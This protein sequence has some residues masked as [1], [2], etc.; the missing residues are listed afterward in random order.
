MITL[1]LAT[2]VTVA[3]A[4]MM[5]IAFHNHRHFPRL[6]AAQTRVDG[7]LASA[8]VPARNEVGSIGEIVVSLLC[9]D[10][11]CLHELLVL[12]DHSTDETARIAREAAADDP[13]F[14]LLSGAPL[15]PGW[16]GKNWAC[17]QLAQHARGD[18]LVFTD[19]DVIWQ[20]GALGAVS[21]AM[22]SMQADLLTVWPTQI[23]ITWA[24]RLVVPM[25]SFAVLA[26]LPIRWAH[27]LP[28]PSAAAANGQCMAFRRA[29]YER[30]GGHAAVAAKVLEDVLLAQRVKAS[31]GKLR[32]ADGAGL[33]QARMYH[34][35]HEVLSGYA[36]NILAGH[37]NSI[38]FLL[39]SI[40]FH[41]SV[42]VWPW[43]WLASRRGIGWPG[44]PLCLIA[45]GLGVRWLCA[46]TAQQRR[47]DIL[48]TPLSVLLMT[49]IAAQAIWWRLRGGAI[50][51]GRKM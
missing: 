3:L 9:Q 26:Y 10:C 1:L 24:E 7:M 12:D 50:W 29:A 30:C 13:R 37:A 45:A 34:N 39:F 43:L 33:I 20:P 8:L 46:S 16:L 19:A 15:P 32:M 44:W 49:R 27:N 28:Y 17:H 4:V 41:L 2:L 47:L 22:E 42:F 23:T 11:L 51:K 48:F 25:M 14:V 40:V 21:A 6:Y 38:L 31:G 36:K 5:A 18:L 35:W